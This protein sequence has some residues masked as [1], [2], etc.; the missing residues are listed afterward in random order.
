MKGQECNDYFHQ[1]HVG[2]RPPLHSQEGGGEGCYPFC[3]QSRI[4]EQIKQIQFLGSYCWLVT[5]MFS[6][7][8][9]IW[10]AIEVELK[11]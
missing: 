5:Q 3:R 9:S 8:K 6:V 11:M 1:Y 2:R 10:R 7:S 4:D